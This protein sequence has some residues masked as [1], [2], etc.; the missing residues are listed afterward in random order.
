MHVTIDAIAVTS[1]DDTEALA[2]IV[3]ARIRE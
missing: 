3:E 1:K 2:I